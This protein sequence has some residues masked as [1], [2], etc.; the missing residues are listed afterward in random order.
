MNEYLSGAHSI[1]SFIESG[2]EE[3]ENGCRWKTY[4]YTDEQ[5]YHYNIFNGVGGI[6]IF[7]SAYYQ[8]TQN[9]KALQ[10]A[11]GAVEWCIESEPEKYNYQRG[12]QFGK[13]GV[14]YSILC[15]SRIQGEKAH[16]DYCLRNAEKIL[17]EP[18]GPITD[19]IGGEASNGWFLLELWKETEDSS[20]LDGAIRCGEWIEQKLVRDELGTHCLVDPEVKKFGSKPYSGL[21]H[22]ISGVAYFFSALYSITLENKWRELSY[23]LFDTLIRHSL[24]DKGGINWSPVLG[25][26]DLVRCQY[27]HGSPGIGLAFLKASKYFKD[28][29]LLDI[30]IKAGEA[31]YS[32]GDYRNNPTF[33]TGLACGGELMIE[34]YKETNKVFWHDRA[35]EFAEMAISYRIKSENGDLWPTDTEG[36]YSPDFTY[37]ASGTGYFLLRVF[38]PD[39]FD[40]PLM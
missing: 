40:T 31:T 5:H 38:E 39:R 24:P 20:H 36:C 30:A 19:L 25:E 28:S 16:L 37:G 11:Y 26:K 15:L 6:P 7:L 9:E 34:L 13:T 8:V 3:Q 32:N 29:G 12:V 33:C 2:A 18:P 23:E 27:S 21:A 1:F 4:N 10:L 35:K 17:D 22:G 14:A